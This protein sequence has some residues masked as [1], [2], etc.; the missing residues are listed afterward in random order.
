M[1]WATLVSLG[2]DDDGG[3]FTIGLEVDDGNGDTATDTATL[4]ITNTPPTITVTGATSTEQ[5]ALYVLNLGS[6]DPGADTI[7]SWTINWG[8]GTIE[9]LAG[10]PLA[11]VHAYTDRG[12]TRDIVASATD[13]DGTWWNAELIVPGMATAD[14]LL[15]Y[16]PV[17]GAFVDNLMDLVGNGKAAGTAWGPDGDL[18]VSVWQ[19][20][21]R[22]IHRFD[23]TT[24]AYAGVF[25]PDGTGGLGAPWG[26]TFGPDGHLY[27]TSNSPD[28]VFRFNGDTGSFIDLFASP[29]GNS[30]AAPGALTFGPDNDLFVSSFSSDEVLRSDGTTGAYEDDF[31]TAG[32]G[33]LA[34]PEGLFFRDDGYLYVASKAE[35]SVK[36]Y[37]ATDR[38]VRRRLRPAR[39]RLGVPAGGHRVRPRRPPVRVQPQHRSGQALRRH[40]EGLS[41][42]LRHRR[43][44]RAHRSVLPELRARSTGARHP[45]GQRRR[46][47]LV[48]R[49]H[50]RRAGDD[51]C[52]T[53]GTNS[54][55][56]AECTL[57]AAIEEAN[58][59]AT[60]DTIEFAIPV[61]DAGYVAGPPTHWTIEPLV[62]L[63]AISQ[64]VTIDASTQPFATVTTGAYPAPIDGTPAIQLVGT[65]ASGTALDVTGGGSEIRGFAING[66]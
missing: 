12:Y 50:G 17:T 14:Q 29:V 62:S 28:G 57:R 61:T 20:P 8:D 45:T 23:G 51:V 54:D 30:L 5:G 58:A 32:L 21:N 25:V 13:E 52:N 53:G 16:E 15:R 63:P 42:E 2:L 36:R 18:Y 59:S 46:R 65:T 41:G 37:S 24:L 7:T 55:G 27:V 49:R 33:G 19:A 38:R 6:S 22:G 60:V 40:H 26:L 1:T 66:S 64:P 9:T 56:R 11:A 47:E 4:T 39:W 10:N 31:V 48:G 43:Q 44:R 35:H 34:E 3:P